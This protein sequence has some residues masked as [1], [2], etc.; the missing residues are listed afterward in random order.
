[1]KL[2]TALAK[3]MAEL[4]VHA[5]PAT[6]KAYEGDLQKLVTLVQLLAGEGCL[7]WTSEMTTKYFLAESN[8]GNSTSTMHRRRAALNQF[9]AWGVRNR[10]FPDN[11]MR[12]A[13]KL[14]LKK[15][16][17]RPFSRPERERLMALE[18]GL[19]DRLIRGL[20]Y[21]TGLRVTPICEIKIG[22]IWQDDKG[23]PVRLRTVGKG[24]VEAWK[25]I[26][27]ELSAIMQDYLLQKTDL[28]PRSY[29][30]AQ[31][32]G[33]AWT[34]K[35]VGRRTHAWGR[36]VEPEIPQCIPHRF[37]HSYATAMLERGVN[38]RKIQKLMNHADISTTMLYVE[39]T[40]L[41]L[42]EAAMAISDLRSGPIPNII[43]PAET[44]ESSPEGDRD[45]THYGPALSP[46][47]PPRSRNV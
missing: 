21:Y 17:P 3:F 15:R 23:R 40:D 6:C 30:L 42:D 14:R 44:S 37:R 1:M 34:R 33:Q 45:G 47:H 13:P 31:R 10:I 5:S 9:A 20:L 24:S 16:L 28:N 4:R 19:R 35:M 38:V 39:V 41:E 36:L 8:K 18:L 26:V 43:G 22:D 46:T 25:L 11:P 2:T 12:E 29:L 32:S 27:P 7:N